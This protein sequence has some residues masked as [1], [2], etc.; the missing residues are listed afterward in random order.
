MEVLHT[1]EHLIMRVMGAPFVVISYVALAATE[2][3]LTMHCARWPRVV[4]VHYILRT[5]LIMKLAYR[6]RGDAHSAKYS[7]KVLLFATFDMSALFNLCAS[8]IFRGVSALVAAASCI[9]YFAYS[10]ARRG[11]YRSRII[12]K[13]NICQRIP[14]SLKRERMHC[15]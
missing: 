15:E 2:H 10:E 14:I 7:Q 6:M 9:S 12:L 11:G 13:S 5:R 1:G 3:E 8:C 4:N